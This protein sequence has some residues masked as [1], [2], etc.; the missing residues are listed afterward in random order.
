MRRLGQ[1]SY[2]S[3]WDSHRLPSEVPMLCTAIRSY[4]ADRRAV[5]ETDQIMTDTLCA[6]RIH[7]QGRVQ[8]VGYRPFVLRLALQAGVKGWVQNVGGYVVIQAEGTPEQLAAFVDALMTEAPPLARPEKPVVEVSRL[9]GLPDFAIRASAES[10]SGHIVIPPDHFV[11][12]DC[13]AE[14]NDPADR[15]YRYPFTHC[16]QCGPRYTLIDRVPYDRPN[17]GMAGFPLCPECQAEYDDPAN[18]RYHAQPLACPVCGPVLEFSRPDK[19]AIQGN[20]LALAA[21]VASLRDGQIVA[22][23]GVGGYHLM[24]DASSEQVVR[25]LRERKHRPAKP[26]AVMMRER[27]VSDVA[28]PNADEWA[29]LRSPLRPIVLVRKRADASLAEAI[30]PGLNEVGIMLPYSPL[31]HLLLEAFD[32]PLV[33]TSANLSG[34]PVLTESDMVERRLGG[35]A[36]AF[37]HHNRPIRRPA[38]DSVFR[39]AGGKRR[40]LRL[41]RG[42]APVEFKLRT[43]LDQ[44]LLAVGAD[45]KNTVALA[46][47][48]RVIIS[49]H[50]GDLGAPRS[51]EVFG[52]VIGDLCRLYNVGLQTLVC[53]AHPDYYSSRWALAQGKPVMPVFHHAAH[54]S[55][56]FEECAVDEPMLVFTWDGLGYG[57]D[58]TLWGGEAL[59]G[60]PGQWQRLASLRPLRLIGGDKASRDPW[61]C[62][63][64]VCLDSGL[65]WPEAPPESTL[66]GVAWKRG[67]NCPPT[68]SAGRLFDAAAALIGVA[69]TQSYEGHAAMQM[70]AAALDRSSTGIPLPL[71]QDG[72]LLRVDWRPLLPILMDGSKDA[73]E[74]SALFHDSLAGSLLDQ[75]LCIRERR[76][77]RR[78]GLTGGVFQNRRLMDRALKG[79]VAAG[80]EVL[81]PERLPVNDAA[82][83]FG[84]IVE[85][86][87]LLLAEQGSMTLPGSAAGSLRHDRV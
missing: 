81:I 34:V 4:R 60:R 85:A 54:A 79:L 38:D 49:P 48:D 25:R 32:G 50:L 29:L 11:C 12:P 3:R 58:G 67:L 82:I 87:A 2:S 18:R 65:D 83:S 33:A 75:A 16:T 39:L 52:Q 45:L 35:V 80:F 6:W 37:L 43:P 47:N 71:A 69:A 53:D 44:P 36:D 62:G 59:C 10:S 23:K 8:G 31:H 86:Q 26:L 57:Q 61:R 40:P 21:C 1:R 28:E 55:A 66:A 68:S 46:W 63:L 13:L 7:V 41:G 70:E 78:V 84:Q 51:L 76:G 74:R 73:A 15:R 17:T 20:E 22:V 19:P 14:M 56:L 42:L 30:A 24:C 27:A 77:I 64:S 9:D 72:E 5:S